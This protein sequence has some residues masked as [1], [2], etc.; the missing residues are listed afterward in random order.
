MTRGS[1]GSKS[2]AGRPVVDLFCGAGG[3]TL[4]AC[5]AGFDPVLAV[6]IDSDLTSSFRRNFPKTSLLTADLT[7]TAGARLRSEVGAGR[8]AGVIGGPP[9]QGFS[10]IGRRTADDP[11]NRLVVRFFE[12]VADLDPM[13]FVMENVPMLGADE[14]STLLE[15][16]IG[17]VPDKYTVLSP[18]RLDASMYGAATERPRL[19]VVGVDTSCADAVTTG[20]FD[21]RRRRT[22]VTVKDAIADL[23]SPTASSE[24]DE[25]PYRDVEPTAAYAR[26]LR[27][28]PPRG[29]GTEES[30][31]RCR[32]DVVTGNSRTA[33]SPAVRRRFRALSQGER[34]RVSRYPRLAW[35]SPAPVL[36][37]GTGSDRGSYQAARPIHP[38]EPRVISVREAAR[39]QGFPDW[40]EFSP[41]KWHSHRMIGNSV[42]PIFAAGLFK[43]LGRKVGAS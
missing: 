2:E 20:D 43:V 27:K 1:K 6:D 25:L 10:E 15:E 19:V 28:P 4:G 16:A 39:L 26:R 14:H 22:P 34:D 35:D 31:S 13:F 37:A 5:L 8:I 29:L 21:S 36:R 24:S 11:R 38:D 30:R 3:F 32:L 18:M 17:R 41:T 12:L 42:S 40:F 7:G 23:P 33:H 9:C